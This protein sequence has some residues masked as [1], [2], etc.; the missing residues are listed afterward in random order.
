MADEQTEDC[1]HCAL[2]HALGEWGKDLDQVPVE[3]IVADLGEV[4]GHVMACAGVPTDLQDVGPLLQLLV[5]ATA[6]SFRR[7]SEEAK[8]LGEEITESSA[9]HTLQ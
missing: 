5:Q 3:D 2:M 9:G 6:D 8:K 7:Y 4:A 1:L